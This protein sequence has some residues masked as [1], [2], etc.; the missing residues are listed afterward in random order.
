M[1]DEET[2]IS[3]LNSLMTHRKIIDT[4]DDQYDLTTNPD[5]EDDIEVFED[6]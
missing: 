1:D 6:D 5:E 3:S 2:D 4:N